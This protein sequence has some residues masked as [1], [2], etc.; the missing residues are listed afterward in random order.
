MNELVKARAQKRKELVLRFEDATNATDEA[1]YRQLLLRQEKKDLGRVCEEI[2]IYAN[3]ARDGTEAARNLD[4]FRQSHVAYD[5]RDCTL[6]AYDQEYRDITPASTTAPPSRARASC[7]TSSV[8]AA[9]HRFN[10]SSTG[11]A[12]S[13][14]ATRPARSRLYARFNSPMTHAHHLAMFTEL[15]AE[16]E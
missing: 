6:E 15:Q 2:E 7:S 4:K 14:A 5:I 3:T 11:N 9:H 8:A 16:R 12:R 13:S 10:W 1:V